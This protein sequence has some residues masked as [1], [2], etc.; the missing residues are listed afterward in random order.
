MSSTFTIGQEIAWGKQEKET[1]ESHSIQV[2][3][4]YQD[5]YDELKAFLSSRSSDRDLVE[6]ILQEVYLRLMEMPDLSVI[7]VP[8][9]YLNRIANNLLI[10]QLRKQSRVQR[11]TLDESV[12]ELE[13]EE[14]SQ[15]PWEKVHYAQQLARYAQILSELPPPAL[16]ILT[17]NKLEGL[18]HGEI[19]K[20][21][22][23]S[24]S[25]VEKSIAKT[26]LHC[27]KSLQ[28]Y[29]F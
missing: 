6:V 8:S 29:D 9:A 1:P 26:L 5:H 3:R 21:F 2:E 19:A 13:I 14:A 27:R 11:R 16:E 7:Q 28:D 22:G 18:T 25:W 17:L 4:I 23:R 12:D 10:D 15:A 20:K 24:K